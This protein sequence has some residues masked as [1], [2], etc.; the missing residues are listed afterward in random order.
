MENLQSLMVESLQLLFIGMGSVFTILTMLIFLITI[1]SKLLP[2]ETV[3]AHKPATRPTN[4][5]VQ[6]TS[7]NGEIVAAI[8]VA[9]NSF[10]NKNSSK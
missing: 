9:V 5:N 8:S 1:I 3:V 4:N 6:Q 10:R 7:N 2:E